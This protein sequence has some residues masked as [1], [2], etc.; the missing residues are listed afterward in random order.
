MVC[1]VF[2]SICFQN[3]V[4]ENDW[5]TAASDDRVL[6]RI[7]KQGVKTGLM[8]YGGVTSQLLNLQ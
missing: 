6:P 2:Q 3:T 8:K 7:W 4:D 5:L 1:F